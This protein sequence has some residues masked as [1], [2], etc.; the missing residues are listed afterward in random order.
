M[1]LGPIDC[2]AYLHTTL[3]F[4]NLFTYTPKSFDAGL[5]YGIISS[6]AFEYVIC[7]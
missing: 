3:I 6:I 2:N 4:P 7:Y 5:R 1:P